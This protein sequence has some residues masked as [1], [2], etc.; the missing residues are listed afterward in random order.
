MV[1]PDIA[2][3]LQNRILH[4][5][6]YNMKREDIEQ[7]K[8]GAIC[9]CC[10]DDMPKKRKGKKKVITCKQCKKSKAKPVPRILD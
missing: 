1:L 4:S 8:A 6:I 2:L 10:G 3:A 9:Q 5:L 7:V